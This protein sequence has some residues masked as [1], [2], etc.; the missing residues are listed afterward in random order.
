VV[1]VVVGLGCWEVG[2]GADAVFGVDVSEELVGL[3]V[4]GRVGRRPL[5][6]GI[7]KLISGLLFVCVWK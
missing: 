4:V 1:G 3:S 2:V 7:G 5:V 6:P